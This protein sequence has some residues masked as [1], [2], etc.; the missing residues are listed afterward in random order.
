[1]T[2]SV[3]IA[4]KATTTRLYEQLKN[5]RILLVRIEGYM[6]MAK[7]DLNNEKLGL[8]KLRFNIKTGNVEGTV[9]NGRSFV[10]NLTENKTVLMAKGLKQEQIDS[11]DCV[12]ACFA[13]RQGHLQSHQ[14]SQAERLHLGTP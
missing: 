2:D 11:L 12:A 4:L 7:S 3:N 14:R 10:N 9:L 13:S 5:L 6:N 8:V 1:M